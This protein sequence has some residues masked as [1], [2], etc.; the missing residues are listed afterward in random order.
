MS[1]YARIKSGTGIYQENISDRNT[2]SL[3]L[4]LRFK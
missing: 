3:I 1:R 4:I 2:A